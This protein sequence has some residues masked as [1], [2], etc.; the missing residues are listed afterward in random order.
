MPPT[1]ICSFTGKSY[2]AH[3]NAPPK[4]CPCGYTFV[5]KAPKALGERERRERVLR[6]RMEF[7]GGIIVPFLL[8]M[9]G[10]G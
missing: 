8:A 6:E 2:H 7:L 3:E 4:P 10:H 9:A 1:D 5:Y